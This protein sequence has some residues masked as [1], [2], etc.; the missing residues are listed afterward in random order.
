[1]KFFET[2]GNLENMFHVRQESLERKEVLLNR[3][4]GLN[5]QEVASEST[6]DVSLR[7]SQKAV[8]ELL[9]NMGR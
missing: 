1:M 4:E 3:S 2:M 9:Q 6:G 5:L 8:A 7:S